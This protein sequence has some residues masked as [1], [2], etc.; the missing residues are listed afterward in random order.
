MLATPALL[1]SPGWLFAPGYRQFF[2]VAE[3]IAAI[4]ELLIGPQRSAIS[5]G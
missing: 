2:S 1:S 5:D 3:I 4:E